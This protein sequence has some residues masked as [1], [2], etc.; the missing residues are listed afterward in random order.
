ME[1]STNNPSSADAPDW[2]AARSPR[3]IALGMLALVIAFYISREH[4]NHLLGVWPY[5]LLLL[6]PLMHLFSHHGHG[7]HEGTAHRK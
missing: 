2:A 7:R 4:W 3:V 5:L 6:C 1:R